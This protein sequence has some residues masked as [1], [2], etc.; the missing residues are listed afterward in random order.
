MHATTKAILDYNK[1]RDPERL[2]LKLLALRG[3]PFAFFRGTAPLFYDT[4]AMP[5]S[6]LAA[7]KVLACGD[8]HLEN[9]GS[10]KADNRLTYFDL[11]DFDE[12]CVAP[13][14]FEVVRFLASIHVGEKYL[15][16]GEKQANS[17]V[18]TFID[19]YTAALMTTKPRWVER[20]TAIGPVKE[21]L[22]S[23]K[24]RHRIDLIRKR[25]EKKRGKI[26][27]IA[28][29]E[30]ALAASESDKARAESI[31]SAYASTQP[32]PAFFEPIAIA[33]R[34]AGNGSLGLERYVVLVRGTGTAEGRYLIDVKFIGPSALATATKGRQPAW[35]SE[36]ERAS[37]AQHVSQAIPPALLGAVGAGRRSYVIKELQPSADRVNLQALGGKKGALADIVRTM[38]EVAAWG[39]LRGAS[40]FGADSADALAQFVAKP[41]W[42]RDAI[43]LSRKTSKAVLRQWNEF[44]EDYDRAAENQGSA[45][46][47]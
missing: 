25:T 44:C 37:W 33:R 31:L 9:F 2:R 21:L 29:G 24:N 1:G 26:Q 15:K 45:A 28:D 7:P 41:A 23:L 11:N 8:L 19:T 42:R 4:L 35:R 40:R 32:S 17:L 27:I 14:T 10:Y 20:A 5:K 43:Q 18:A 16:I 30:H 38:A 36:G 39:H 6:L 34:I 3:D 47:C 22:Q 13:L 12:A 46:L